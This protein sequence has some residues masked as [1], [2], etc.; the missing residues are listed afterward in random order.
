MAEELIAVQ[1]TEQRLMDKIMTEYNAMIS[2]WPAAVVIIIGIG[3][4]ANVPP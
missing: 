4:M 3:T 1:S 2:V